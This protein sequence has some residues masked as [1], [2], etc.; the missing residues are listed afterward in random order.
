[1]NQKASFL[2]NL[3]LNDEIVKFFEKTC[4]S[5]KYNDKRMRIKFNRKKLME[6]GFVKK[7]LKYYLKQNK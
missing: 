5:E 4:K 2:T 1:L 3:I 6:D 7:N